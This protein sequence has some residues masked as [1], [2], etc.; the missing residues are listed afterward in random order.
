MS[1]KPQDSPVRRVRWVGRTA[2]VEAQGDI[3][4]ARSNRFQHALLEVLDER[5]ERMVVDLADVPY[6]DSSGVAS[7]VKLLARAGRQEVSLR[8]AGMSRRVRSIFEITRLDTVF[9]IYPTQ[10]EALV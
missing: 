5:P 8:L 2:V 10:E 7:L 1:A 3:D 4:L 9:E 6:M